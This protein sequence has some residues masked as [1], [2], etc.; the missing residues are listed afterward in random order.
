MAESLDGTHYIT[1]DTQLSTTST[2]YFRIEANNCYTDNYYDC[3]NLRYPNNTN[4]NL[5]VTNKLVI[6]SS[7]DYSA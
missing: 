3:Q 5:D 1:K 6:Q 7:G 4:V 2:S